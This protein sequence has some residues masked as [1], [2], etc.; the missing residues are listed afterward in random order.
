MSDDAFML[1][2]AAQVSV[3]AIFSF[4]CFYRAWE[5]HLAHHA[6]RNALVALGTLLAVLTV[7]YSYRVWGRMYPVDGRWM[8]SSWHY[9]GVQL[10][11]T[12]ALVALFF[13]LQKPGE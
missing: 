12:I 7:S 3:C 6:I 1:L 2:Y 4:A 5:N 11:S 13:L 9:F 8:L 10:A